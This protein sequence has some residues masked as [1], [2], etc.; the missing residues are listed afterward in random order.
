M[1]FK[2][3]VMLLVAPV[4]A[5][6]QSAGERWSL[7]PEFRIGSVDGPQ[8]LTAVTDLLLS[9][10]GRFIYV[11]QGRDFTV[12]EFDT[13]S[14]RLVRS[15]GRRG[16]GPGEFQS[17]VRIGWRQD[18]LYATDRFQ[19]RV[20][21][22]SPSGQHY[23]T[24]RIA[25]PP[26]PQTQSAATPVAIL[27][28]GSVVGESPLSTIAAARGLIQTL[29]LVEMTRD[30]KLVRTLAERDIRGIWTYTAVG[31]RVVVFGQPLL[32]YK[33]TQ[34][35]A[36]DGSSVILVDQ[37]PQADPGSTFQVTRLNADGDTLY[38]H[39]Y[40]YTPRPVPA[41]MADSIYQSYA[42]LFGGASSSAKAMEAVKKY[43]KLPPAQPPV[44]EVVLGSDGTA[45]LRREESASR[46]VGWL[47]L[48]PSGG[49]RATLTTPAGVRILALGQDV[50][51]GV[52]HDELDVPFVVRYRIQRSP[53]GGGS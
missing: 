17:L 11:A 5:Y 35:V 8:A 13:R 14:G 34:D 2:I 30:G 50:V 43:V 22:F 31:D 1:R 40:R 21:L 48:D 32:Q 37:T 46:T 47:V 45:W 16:S 26:L 4:A 52:T 27:S 44:S 10:D 28:N 19:Q 15:I 12:R 33:F 36:P 6:A 42:D 41:A 49:V 51:W 25:S 38:H 7:T 23:S 29:P 9:P 20:S 39:V 3:V 53:R 18:T 24:E